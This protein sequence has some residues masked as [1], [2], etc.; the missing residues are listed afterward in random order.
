MENES[1]FYRTKIHAHGLKGGRK[2]MRERGESARVQAMGRTL[3][4]NRTTYIW[5]I[6]VRQT[7]DT[8]LLNLV[9][10]TCK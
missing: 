7:H 3:E 10:Q 9:E 1:T 4:G 8:F 2:D 5:P 6:D